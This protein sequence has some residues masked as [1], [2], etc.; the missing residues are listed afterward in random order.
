MRHDR[1][2]SLPG[3]RLRR[4]AEEY[5]DESA[6]QSI[7]LPVIADLQYEYQAVPRNT[8]SRWLHCLRGYWSFWKAISLH[9]LI[10]GDVKMR[11]SKRLSFDLVSFAVILIAGFEFVRPSYL[12]GLAAT[13]HSILFWTVQLLCCLAGLALALALRVRITAY[14]I[15]GFIAFTSCEIA[16]RAYYWVMLFRSPAHPSVSRGAM[17]VVFNG[18]T[19]ILSFRGVNALFPNDLAVMG[20]AL[21]GVA[22][23]AILA[24]WGSKFAGRIRPRQSTAVPG[25]P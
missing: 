17:T 18:R 2:G 8:M 14:C 9:T 23:G 1:S 25:N 4:F 19:S 24:L 13:N 5:L 20:A 7:V 15:A 12:P 22:L 11:I 10:N 6:V 21:L 3:S 16:V